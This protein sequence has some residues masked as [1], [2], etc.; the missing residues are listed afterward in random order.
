MNYEEFF[1][2]FE[3]IL[4]TA[5]DECDDFYHMEIDGDGDIVLHWAEYEGCN[6]YV[7]RQTDT[8]LRKLWDKTFPQKPRHITKF[9]RLLDAEVQDV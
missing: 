6:D 7:M 9:Q 2:I 3:R 1:T 8:H 5:R 4:E